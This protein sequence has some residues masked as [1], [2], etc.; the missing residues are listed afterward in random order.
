MLYFIVLLL[1]HACFEIC[2]CINFNLCLLTGFMKRSL[3]VTLCVCVNFFE[4]ECVSSLLHDR[5]RWRYLL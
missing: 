5:G 4:S 3:F 1:T 2:F